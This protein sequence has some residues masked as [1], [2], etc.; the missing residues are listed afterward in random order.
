MIKSASWD[1]MY[2]GSIEAKKHPFTGDIFQKSYYKLEIG[3]I[4]IS[5]MQQTIAY[6]SHFNTETNSNSIG[7]SMKYIIIQYSP[8]LK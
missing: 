4:I 6:F 1:A 7:C 3:L 5:L 2:E 8:F